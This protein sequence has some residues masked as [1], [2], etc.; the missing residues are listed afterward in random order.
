MATTPRINL[1]QSFNWCQR[2]RIFHLFHAFTRFNFS[3]IIIIKV[4][5]DEL[6]A[7]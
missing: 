6:I 1:L 7:I 5:A 3:Y 2:P 4:A